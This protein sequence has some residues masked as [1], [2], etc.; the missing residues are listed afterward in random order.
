M[1]DNG[2]I[3][4]LEIL[5]ETESKK[6]ISQLDDLKNALKDVRTVLTS[7]SK[8]DIDF[9]TGKVKKAKVA[10]QDFMKSIKDIG[11]INVDTNNIKD[12]E[13]EIGKLENRL[14][15]LNARKD[16]KET[17]HGKPVGRENSSSGIT[18]SFEP[19]IFCSCIL[20]CSC[21]VMLFETSD[22]SSV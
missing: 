19:I 13:I 7:A 22:E 17:F 12:V 20:R 4:S 10:Y 16:K 3:D 14:K 21:T 8:Q 9:G 15:T 18:S 5:V 6:A 11:K 1:A 2:Q